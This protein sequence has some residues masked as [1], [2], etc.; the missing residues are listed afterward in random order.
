MQT[1]EQLA[2][3]ERRDQR[4]KKSPLIQ[5]NDIMHENYLTEK[6]A[7]SLMTLFYQ[8][9]RRHLRLKKSLSIL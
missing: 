5:E 7:K 4:K 6:N 8:R 9:V 2:R 1:D 3:Q